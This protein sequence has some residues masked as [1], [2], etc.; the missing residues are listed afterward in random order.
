MKNLKKKLTNNPKL[1]CGV[2]LRDAT[3]EEIADIKQWLDVRGIKYVHKTKHL[4]TGKPL[5]YNGLLI[6]NY[7][8]TKKN[9]KNLH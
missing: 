6:I 5:P 1:T 7:V 3:P 8:G 4:K 9:A 2:G